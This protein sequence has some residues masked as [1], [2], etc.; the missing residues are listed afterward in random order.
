M[1]SA[2][3]EVIGVIQLVN[4][5]AKGWVQLDLPADFFEVPAQEE[6]EAAELQEA[7]P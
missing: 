2:R 3:A 5:R 4:K 6:E 7:A 1:I